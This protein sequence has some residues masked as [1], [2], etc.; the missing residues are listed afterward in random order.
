MALFREDADP[1]RVATGLG[2]VGFQLTSAQA[3]FNS[4]TGIAVVRV[5]G[6][7][8]STFRTGRSKPLLASGTIHSDR[9]TSARPDGSMTADS[10]AP[11]KILRGWQGLVSYDGAEAGYFF[12]KQVGDGLLSGL[13]LWDAK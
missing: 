6:D 11:S 7:L 9:S 1:R 5:N 12:E 10:F 13:T 8:G 2:D 4:D 3:A